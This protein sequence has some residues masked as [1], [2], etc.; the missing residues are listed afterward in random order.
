MVNESRAVSSPQERRPTANVMKPAQ[1][2]VRKPQPGSGKAEGDDESE[3]SAHEEGDDQ[4]QG[5]HL[6]RSAW[7]SE[8]DHADHDVDE[9]HEQVQ[10]KP[11]L[12]P[13]RERGE[14]LGNAGE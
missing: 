11:T 8:E 3:D 10:E 12:L 13:H 9:A 5:Q 1:R 6:R 4:E 2:T 7:V 14:H